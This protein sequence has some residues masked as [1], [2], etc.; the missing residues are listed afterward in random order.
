MNQLEKSGRRH[1]L[2]IG[3][4]SWKLIKHRQ[5]Q[6]NK[7][8]NT[9]RTPIPIMYSLRKNA[10]LKKTTCYVVFEGNM[11]RNTCQRFLALQHVFSQA[12]NSW[13][14]I[15]PCQ[16]WPWSLGNLQVVSTY[17][18]GSTGRDR[19]KPPGKTNSLRPE[20]TLAKT[21]QNTGCSSKHLFSTC[22]WNQ[23]SGRETWKKTTNT[24]HL[25]KK[26][27]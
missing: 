14:P 7:M 15:P 19:Q 8:N 3:K 23:S 4:F 17:N 13:I 24:W 25:T 9:R 27:H 12:I 1:R 2:N 10:A 21:P 18:L 16:Y 11:K 6:L 20:K 5:I 26:M 22:D